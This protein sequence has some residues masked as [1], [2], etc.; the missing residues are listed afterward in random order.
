[1]AGGELNGAI[2]GGKRCWPT[3]DSVHAIFPRASVDVRA[4]PKA[5]LLGSCLSG[6]STLGSDP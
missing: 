6:S 1:M 4:W 2:V 5:L 3:K